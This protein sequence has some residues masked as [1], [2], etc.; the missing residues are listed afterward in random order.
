MLGI[1]MR[2][3]AGV[4]KGR[5]DYF[6]SSE[7]IVWYSPSQVHDGEGPL[8]ET[9]FLL[10]TICF[11][12]RAKSIGLESLTQTPHPKLWSGVSHLITC[13]PIFFFWK[14]LGRFHY[15]YN[16]NYCHK[17]WHSVNDRSIHHH[18][19]AFLSNPERNAPSSCTSPLIMI[20][21]SPS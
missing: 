15:K 20:F 8:R 5:G 19:F 18:S 21:L 1:M 7:F 4:Q 17:R 14:T 2:A 10:S 9:L 11:L 12:S 6:S 3:G 13:T 16:E